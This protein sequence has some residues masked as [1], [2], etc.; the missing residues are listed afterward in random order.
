MTTYGPR[1]GSAVRVTVTGHVE[2][3]LGLV[4]VGLDLVLGL[5]LESEAFTGRG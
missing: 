3:Q 1:R 2:A 5:G 4:G